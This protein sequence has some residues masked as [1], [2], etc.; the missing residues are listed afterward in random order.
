[1]G[2]SGTR[3][4][5]RER[6]AFVLWSGELGGAER[7]T[8][9]VCR[10]LRDDWGVDAR[11]VFIGAPDRAE[12][13]LA[14]AGVPWCG[15]GLPRGRAVLSNE[16][17]LAQLVSESGANGAFLVYGGYLARALRRGGYG[18]P[19][20]S[21]EHGGIL[22]LASQ[23]F[24]K[25]AKE[26]I[27]RRFGERHLDAT[28]CVSRFIEGV[29]RTH[30]HAHRL[31]T[32]YNGIDTGRYS[33]ALVPPQSGTCVFGL[34]GRL[35]EGK[36]VLHLVSSFEQR[37]GE[38]ACSLAIAGAGPALEAAKRLAAQRGVSDSVHFLGV[39]DD[40]AEFWRA[41]SVVVQPTDGWIESFCLSLVEG[42]ACG[43]PAIVSDQG[44][45]PEIL[46]EGCG[47]VVTPGDEQRLRAAMRRYATDPG[48][49]LRDGE[50]ARERSVETFDIH[51]T[52]GAYLR[53][54]REIAAARG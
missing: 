18:A 8:V 30:P 46:G 15:M 48:L 14:E 43:L 20:I 36:G 23:P 45:L 38:V 44:A 13:E 29:V 49:R 32:I 4:S 54:L 17:G 27:S 5:N 39:V 26:E 10:A 24:L 1:M 50:C 16:R 41:C 21:V 11:V 31:V 25:R 9:Q 40:M 6:L 3:P 7:H 35:I 33:P 47:A 52:A 22:Q 51:A 12:R 28:V 53:V 34:A 2:D 37:V 42:M 19:L